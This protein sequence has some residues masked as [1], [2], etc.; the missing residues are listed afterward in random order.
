ML[1][2]GVL[3]RCAQYPVWEMAIERGRI[4]PMDFVIG[5]SLVVVAAVL[6]GM[7]Y[8]VRYV[9]KHIKEDAARAEQQP[10]AKG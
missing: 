5:L 6:V 7:G 8:A 4:M 1:L 3:L 2:L 9:A 10:R